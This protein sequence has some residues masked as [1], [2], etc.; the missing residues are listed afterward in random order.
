MCAE[1]FQE[2]LPSSRRSDHP[3]NL[4]DHGAETSRFRFKL[5]EERSSAAKALSGSFLSN[6]FKVI[7]A[8][9]VFGFTSG[10]H[11]AAAVSRH[12][13]HEEHGDEKTKKRQGP[14]S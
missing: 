6:I 1:S 5:L 12:E 4:F 14:P 2:V 7:G 9:A 11:R 8:I 3:P 13:A 10:L